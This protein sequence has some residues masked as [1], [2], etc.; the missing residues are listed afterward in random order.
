MAAAAEHFRQARSEL[1]HAEH[2]KGGWRDR[3]IESADK[4]IRETKA[5][6]EFADTH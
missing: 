2:N 6:C 5:G 4:A 3:A 1:D